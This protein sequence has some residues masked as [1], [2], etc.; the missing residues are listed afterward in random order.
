MK[1]LQALGWISGEITWFVLIRSF[2]ALRH[3]APQLVEEGFRESEV[4]IFHRASVREL[5]AAQKRRRYAVYLD[6]E[7]ARMVEIFN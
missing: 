1:L 3:P 2:A 7:I 6:F 5:P 4:A